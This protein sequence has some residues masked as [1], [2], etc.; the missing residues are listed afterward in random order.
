MQKIEIIHTTP[1][2]SHLRNGVIEE[3]VIALENGNGEP[4]VQR[5]VTHAVRNSALDKYRVPLISARLVLGREVA[6]NAQSRQYVVPVAARP[7]HLEVPSPSRDPAAYRDAD[8]LFDLGE[9]T[10]A[11]ARICQQRVLRMPAE[12]AFGLVDYVD[13]GKRQ[14]YLLPGSEQLLSEPVDKPLD[15]QMEYL[16]GEF[17]ENFGAYADQF[18]QGYAIGL[19]ET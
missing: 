3:D 8:L 2:L 9:L 1:Y 12:D 17:G 7:L 18:I 10:G 14:L 19:E 5:V 13:P 16:G 11:V 4:R 15:K 6:G